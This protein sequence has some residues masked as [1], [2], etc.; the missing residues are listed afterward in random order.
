MRKSGTGAAIILLF[1]SFLAAS[2]IFNPTP[3]CT[4]PVLS[5][6]EHNPYYWQSGR[7]SI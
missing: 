6:K 5:G 7:R 4:G 3:P 1:L 2:L